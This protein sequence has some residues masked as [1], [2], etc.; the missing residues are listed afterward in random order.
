MLASP[1]LGTIT[2]LRDTNHCAVQQRA[3]TPLKLIPDALNIVRRAF[4]SSQRADGV[5]TKYF[6]GLLERSG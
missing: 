2:D 5:L 1:Y 4:M 3:I 6:N